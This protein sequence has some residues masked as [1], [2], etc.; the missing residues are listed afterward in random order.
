ML[1]WQNNGADVD[2]WSQEERIIER[3]REGGRVAGAVIFEVRRGV[4]RRDRERERE[5]FG[6]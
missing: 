4:R 1:F 5:G 2:E 3:W 6:T